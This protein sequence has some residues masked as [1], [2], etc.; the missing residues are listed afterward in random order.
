MESVLSPVVAM[1]A[2]TASRTVNGTLYVR[3]GRR[4]VPAVAARSSVGVCPRCHAAT[5]SNTSSARSVVSRCYVVHS[6]SL[7]LDL[8]AVRVSYDSED[9]EKFNRNL[10]AETFVVR[11]H[12]CDTLILKILWLKSPVY[13]YST[14]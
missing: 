11:F 8:T 7:R 1:K 5:T 9:D 4:S 14:L 6:A 12:V 13:F 2:V 3:G 10:L